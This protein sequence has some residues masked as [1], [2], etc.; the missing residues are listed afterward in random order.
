MEEILYLIVGAAWLLFNLYKKSQENKANKEAGQTQQRR[1]YVPEQQH[2]A[3]E[4]VYE[5]PQ[6]L[7]EMILERFGEKRP[8]P[9]IIR[10]VPIQV[11]PSPFLSND[12]PK[13]AEGQRPRVER[14]SQKLRDDTPPKVFHSDLLKE[15]LDMRKAFI[16]N[17]I[18]QRPYA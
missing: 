12:A 5:A 7:E 11:S 2:E 1:A 17:T 6:T 18:L 14:K 10:H 16:Y 3:E 13:Y 9:Q 4:E 8:E 15:D